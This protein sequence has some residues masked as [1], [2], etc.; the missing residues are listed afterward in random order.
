M[1][2]I[3]AKLA[4]VLSDEEAMGQ[5]MG[6][7]SALG[8]QEGGHPEEADPSAS[9]DGQGPDLASLLGSLGLGGNFPGAGSGG[10]EGAF[11]DPAMLSLLG[12]MA[13]AF[14]ERDRNVELLTALKP[15]FGQPRQGRVEDAIRM[16]KLIHL[17]PM[18]R[19]SGLLENL[20][21]GKGH[22]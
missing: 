10:G 9:P 5:I 1:E 8:G 16:M 20:L 17:L 3:A 11:P 4:Q 2:D 15:Y 18:L 22:G 12:K 21:G 14:Q 19:E 6:L 13:G 7:M